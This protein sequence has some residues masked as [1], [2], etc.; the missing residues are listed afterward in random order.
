[1]GKS[2]WGAS[3]AFEQGLFVIIGFGGIFYPLREGKGSMWMDGSGCKWLESK[4]SKHLT[5]T[6]GVQLLIQSNGDGFHR[7]LLLS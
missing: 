7:G 4:I 6:L 1:M 2:E 3:A 5:K